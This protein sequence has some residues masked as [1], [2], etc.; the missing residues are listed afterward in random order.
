MIHIKL[1]EK[2]TT[3]P[4]KIKPVCISHQEDSSWQIEARVVNYT[5]DLFES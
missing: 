2:L 1:S 5:V 4:K 3:E